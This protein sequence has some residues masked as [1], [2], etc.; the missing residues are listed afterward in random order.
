MGRGGRDFGGPQHQCSS[1]AKHEAAPRGE[2][3]P[4]CP[5]PPS[6]PPP[7]FLSRT[8]DANRQVLRP[9]APCL[10]LRCTHLPVPW[11]PRPVT[12]SD[13]PAMRT[14]FFTSGKRRCWT[15]PWI[16]R[17]RPE[18]GGGLGVGGYGGAMLTGCKGG[19]QGVSEGGSC[20]QTDSWP[21]LHTFTENRG[22]LHSQRVRQG[23]AT[24][25]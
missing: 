5:L 23:S 14:R 25:R 3:L 18:N 19:S 15:S 4:I 1:Q 7:P 24:P 16:T 22:V 21:W 10:T 17:K 8:L 13:A 9:E 2:F 6:G 20:S 12:W 11:D